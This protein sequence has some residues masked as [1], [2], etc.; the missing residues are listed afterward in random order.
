MPRGTP[1]RLKTPSRVVAWAAFV[2]VSVAA[3]AV[4]RAGDPPPAVPPPTLNET[5][6]K[7]ALEGLG[8]DLRRLCASP[9]AEKKREEID[10]TIDSVIALGGADGA[11][12]LLD[13]L[14][15]DD[16]A[17]EKRVLE[18]V[19]TVHEK[20]LVKPLAAVLDDKEN[21][22]RFRLHSLVA[23]ALSVIADPS[24]IP[25]L[26]ELVDS[27]DATVIAAAGDA[28]AVFK[29]APHAKRV[30]A[31]RRMIDRYESTWNLK[32]SR[33]PE[34]RIATDEAKKDWEV[35]GASLRKALQALTGQ[36]QLSRPKQFRDWW[37]DNKKATNW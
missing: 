26:T 27:E 28:L 13:A 25:A 24:A 12:T 15:W 23:H 11:K 14:V 37:N 22:R 17:T 9:R 21:R 35:F 34:D 33:R 29:Q 18:F 30:D 7:E 19:E 2:A 8:K 1:S 32:E 31:V 4:A 5:A 3:P 6:R 10:K 20:S 36:A 16:E